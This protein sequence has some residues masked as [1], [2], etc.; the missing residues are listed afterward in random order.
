MANLRA[1]E[2]GLFLYLRPYGRYYLFPTMP[3]CFSTLL[4][5][6]RFCGVPLSPLWFVVNDTDL[7][8]KS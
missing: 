1:P 2:H 8:V 3:H 4:D 6:V 5:A 7:E